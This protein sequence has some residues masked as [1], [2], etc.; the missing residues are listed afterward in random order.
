MVSG[1]K[2]EAHGIA[3]AGAPQVQERRINGQDSGSRPGAQQSRM[4][5]CSVI[6]GLKIQP[7][8]QIAVPHQE[9]SSGDRGKAI[10]VRIHRNGRNTWNTEIEGGSVIPKFPGKW[11]QEPSGSRVNVKRNACFAGDLRH[12]RHIVNGTAFAGARGDN[13]HRRALADL[14][15]QCIDIDSISRIQ[16]HPDKLNIQNPGNLFH[17][18]VHTLGRENL[19]LSSLPPQTPELAHRSVD[20]QQIC[21]SATGNRHARGATATQQVA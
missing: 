12:S 5:G 10:L 6:M 11:D 19:R 3:I 2:K 1:F 17:R 16:S 4:V 15:S 8:K 21:L 13:N 20:R 7:G 14:L 18:E 9:I